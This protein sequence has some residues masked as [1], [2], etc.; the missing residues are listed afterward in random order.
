MKTTILCAITAAGLLFTLSCV[1]KEEPAASSRDDAAQAGP[2]AEPKPLYGFELDDIDGN[3]VALSRFRGKVLLLVNVASKCGYTRQYEGLQT[4]HEKYH[5]RGLTILAFPANNFGDQEPGTNEQIKQFCSATY[6]VAFPVFAKISVKGDDIH[7]LYRFLT[8]SQSHPQF[9]GD[10]AWNF[11]KFL[12]SR[13]GDVIGRYES[14]VEPFDDRLVA[15]I[16]TALSRSE[17]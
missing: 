13:E 14:A 7:P 5:D 9:A 6:G 3:P 16:E 11:S 15:D 12:V 8:S 10:I 17:R 2:A 1:P 4:L